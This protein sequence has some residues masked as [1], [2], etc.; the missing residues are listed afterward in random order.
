MSGSAGTPI[1]SFLVA[2]GFKIDEAGLKKFTQTLATSAVQVTKFALAIQAA[3]AA[4]FVMVKRTSEDLERLYYVAQRSGSS[5]T[6]LSQMEYAMSHIG[7]SAGTA[8]AAVAAFGLSLK[9]DPGN[10]T[11]LRYMGVATEDANGKLKTTDE[12]ITSLVDR[13]KNGGLPFHVAASYVQSFGLSAPDLNALLLGWDKYLAK[14]E[15]VKK[16]REAT[17]F[18]EE[19]AAK[20]SVKLEDAMGKTTRIIKELWGTVF[21]GIAT[22]YTTFFNDFNK[23]LI[24]HSAEITSIGK[25]FQEEMKAIAG[26]IGDIGSKFD[27]MVNASVGWE[28]AFK[29]IGVLIAFYLT[30][31]LGAAV[32]SLVILQADL[33]KIAERAK[34]KG[35]TPH[36]ELQQSLDDNFGKSNMDALRNFF[37][38]FDSPKLEKFQRD[39]FNSLDQPRRGRRR[40]PDGETDEFGG[41][42]P[43]IEGEPARPFKRM[44]GTGFDPS[45]VRLAGGMS[46]DDT[47][48][49]QQ[50][51]AMMAASFKMALLDVFEPVMR[52]VTAVTNGT[53]TSITSLIGGIGSKL[54]GTPVGTGTSDDEASNMYQFAAMM[55]GSFK[56]AL[57]DV[58]EPV[59]RLVTAVTN[60]TQTSITSLIGGIGS[61]LT[62]TTVGTGT[63]GDDVSN[64]YQFAAMMAAAFKMALLDVFG[65]FLRFLDKMIND[66]SG[67]SGAATTSLV[68]DIQ[69]KSTGTPVG[70]PLPPDIEAEIRHQ[71]RIKGLDEDHMVR[72]ARVE[73]GGYN[74][75]NKTSLAR[76]PMQIIP[77]TA[78]ML[79]IDASDWKQNIEGGLRYYASILKGFGS[80]AAADAGYHSGPHHPGAQRFALTGDMSGLGPY[81]RK[82]VT[83][84]N[85]G[86][87][88]PRGDSGSSRGGPTQIIFNIESNDPRGVARAVEE[89]LSGVFSNSIRNLTG[90]EVS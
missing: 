11:L 81:G 47:S 52:L 82:Y 65:P 56:V 40:N 31:P 62:G 86:R 17:G 27:K 64:M 37:K 75:V 44:S 33:N 8:Q 24:K 34:K 48:S 13:I 84:I 77:G 35:S 89:R 80:Y 15:E 71:S 76:G 41:K 79:G 88:G 87:E 1:Q 18:D 67:A 23:F 51:A 26:V 58:F 69:S 20:A 63:S 78:K 29:A 73:Q 2:L 45:M 25:V 36:E 43:P 22:E 85:Y 90:A 21:T 46:R 61:K 39:F 5:I 19:A 28:I 55:T 4:L 72:L 59:M 6:G 70:A 3:Q 74:T 7:L 57:L 14:I 38:R 9:M 42:L 66:A 68:G 12:L 30:G 60:G 83:D 16:I 50:F 32:A 49:T 10:Y 53:Q 54:T